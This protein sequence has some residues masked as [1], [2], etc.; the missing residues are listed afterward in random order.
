MYLNQA[1]TSVPDASYFMVTGNGCGTET[2][3]DPP[4]TFAQL[5][6]SAAAFALDGAYPNPSSGPVTLSFS[7]AEAAPVTLAVY[8]VMGR[9]VTTLV[10]RAMT[11]GVHTVD[12]TGRADSGQALASGVYLL[13]LQAGDEVAT[14]R[15]TVVR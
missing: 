11:A 13:R 4:V 9:R 2:V 8:D 3:I 15:L 1:D 10:D 12:W 7:L 14:R 6:A 5:D